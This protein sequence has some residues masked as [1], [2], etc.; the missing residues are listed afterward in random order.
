MSKHHPITIIL[1]G[2]VDY[3]LLI[4][5]CLS[6]SLPDGHADDPTVKGKG[7]D[8]E[9]LDYAVALSSRLAANG[10]HGQL[11]FYRWQIRNTAIAGSHVFVVY[12][13]PDDTVWVVDNEI[14]HPRGVGKSYRRPA[15]RLL[16]TSLLC[17]LKPPPVGRYARGD[18]L[19]E[20]IFSGR[21]FPRIA[22]N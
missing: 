5:F 15:P 6:E 14:P 19:A 20:I 18:A 4:A 17:I 3:F 11:I 22:V 8:G 12:R 1:G 9:C 21:F 13:L 10:I 16:T 7:K 2:V